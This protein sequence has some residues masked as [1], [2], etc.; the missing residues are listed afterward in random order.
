MAVEASAVLAVLRRSSYRFGHP[1][2][3]VSLIFVI[4]LS[5]FVTK[6]ATV[7]TSAP[8]I[9]VRISTLPLFIFRLHATAPSSARGYSRA[10]GPDRFYLIL[11]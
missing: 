1:V 11:A 7:A 3:V 9:K 2:P 6:V 8:A 5:I 10:G 4:T